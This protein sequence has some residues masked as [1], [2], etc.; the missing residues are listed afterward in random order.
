MEKTEIEALL[1]E[2]NSVNIKLIE[3]MLAKVEDTKVNVK[4]A[5][6]LSDGL[7]F[8]GKSRVD[9]ILL[10]LSL[11]DSKDFETFLSVRTKAEAPIVVLTSLDDETIASKA[12]RE[13]AQDYL[14]KGQVDS[15][16]L[17]RSVRYAIERYRV[18]EALLES[19]E[20]VKKHR[21]HLEEIVRD[22]TKELTKVNESLQGEINERKHAEKTLLK[23]NRALKTLSE[24]N[25]AMVCTSSEADLLKS[26]CKIVV[27]V[28]GYRMA[29]VGFAGQD[30]K[31]SVLPV[32]H[33][34][35][36]DGYLKT[37][38]I[39]WGD[40]PKGYRAIGEAIR[41]CK[42]CIVKNILIESGYDSWRSEAIKRGYISSISLP[43]V[44]NG[45]TFGSLNIYSGE[46]DAFDEEEESLLVE[47]A[48]DLVYGIMAF[49]TEAE[50]RRAE[51]MVEHLAYYDSLT[52][53]PNWILFSKY[54]ARELEVSTE[55]DRH[56]AVMF[57]G[58]DR[59]KTINDTLGHACGDELLRNVAERIKYCVR[60]CDTVARLKGNEFAILVPQVRKNNDMASL[61]K[62][63]LNS[64]K[65]PFYIEK[66]KLYITSGVGIA[67]YPND[68]KDTHT[69]LKN[70]DTAMHNAESEGRDNYKFYT[71]SMNVKAMEYIEI[72]N[73]MRDGMEKGEFMVYYQPKVDLGTG[74]I[75]GME[76]LARWNNK[77]MG[78]VP[79]GKFIPIAE[80]SEFIIPL[81]EWVLRTACKQ[82][83]E[84]QTAGYPDIRMSVN[85]STRQ[86]QQKNLVSMVEE[87]LEE[88]GL[89]ATWLE[90][91][92]T[93]TEVMQNPE[94]AIST[95]KKLSNMGVNISLDDFGT[96]YSSLSY[97]KHLPI[98]TIKIDYS[99][100][101]DI[102]SDQDNAAIVTAIIA[103]SHSLKLRV[104]AEGVETREQLDFLQKLR[105][106]EMQGFFF[107]RPLPNVDIEKML[108]EGRYL[109]I[110]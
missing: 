94:S 107:S 81:G 34:G 88:T 19:K 96:G 60:D 12:V 110:S 103:M 29:W 87:T 68:G 18:T 4:S 76:A 55:Q 83:K 17:W 61:A 6:T 109:R 90:L 78:F 22:R 1:I 67:V 70:A 5:K 40:I 15:G 108:S 69:L 24:C 101:R 66:N 13:G 57:L 14:I 106:E 102:T 38:N 37:L 39:T 42:P 45:R 51:E 93:E 47:L 41:T 65:L 28:G 27:D 31:K 3:K 75:T 100:V 64:L 2:D 92:V 8:I 62:R 105:C 36:E 35:Y 49:R 77:E 71:T 52:G 50:R 25:R 72:E 44:S 74:R 53:L 73:R 99:F 56:T 11:P 104:I 59:L 97:L 58:L 10:D 95:L 26:I 33:A 46:V 7:E 98:N 16:L 86:F 85:L 63:I 9:V 91:E 21:D 80:E 43:L 30:G 54:L 32:T 84:W 48:N 82:N 89:D 79:P 23:V 20:E